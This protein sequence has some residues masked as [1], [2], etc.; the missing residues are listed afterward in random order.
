VKKP[1][2]KKNQAKN[3][4]LADVYL[5][6]I[7]DVPSFINDKTD[8]DKRSPELS[9][10]LKT[11]KSKDDIINQAIENE[12][13]SD[14]STAKANWYFGEWQALVDLDIKALSQHPEV[15]IF[16]ALKA[17]AYQQINE[18]ELSKT[19]FKLA[20]KLGCDKQL[21]NQLLIAGVHN[22]LGRVSALKQDDV[23]TLSHFNAAVN[24]GGKKQ[25]NKLAMHARSVK[26]ISRL[27]LLP[28]A[29]KLLITA[30][31]EE[32][33]KLQVNRPSDNEAAIKVLSSEVEIIHHELALAYEKAQLYSTRGV[34]DHVFNDDGSID[35][36]R[37]KQLSPSQL[38]QDLWALDKTNYKKKGFF[39]EFGATNGILLSNTYLLEKEFEWS[40]ICAEPNPKY[41]EKLQKNRNCTTSDSCI[42]DKT[43]DVVEFILANEYGG[44]AETAKVGLHSDKVVAYE[45]KGEVLSLETISLND[46]LLQ[47]NAPKQIDYLSID[48]EGSEYLILSS[49]P[50][51]E[52]NI[53][54][55]SIEHNYEPQRELIFELLSSL[56]YEREIRE[57]D[58][59][60]FLK[61]DVS[62]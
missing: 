54:C 1:S 10:D 28:Q 6:D 30:K 8:I 38:G 60:Y 35:I 4:P 13:I 47:N 37:L 61:Q 33:K 42:S 16:T 45:A 15:E 49:F 18:I 39:V 32:Q 27:G 9:N 20:R 31:E 56:N 2:N 29:A 22:A 41:F 57:W 7:I 17:A 24:I 19:Y 53:T 11:A 5:D 21:I 59:L 55:M 26:E 25:E 44:M 3:I 46:F 40:G 51:E 52:W 62:N 43:G 12:S 50:F 34:T 14:I 36:D 48:T 58:D 23:K